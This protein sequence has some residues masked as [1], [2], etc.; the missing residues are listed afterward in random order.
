MDISEVSV[1]TFNGEAALDGIAGS[2]AFAIYDE[3][4]NP[5]GLYSP[6]QDGDCGAPYV[7]EENFLKYVLTVT[8]VNF[9]VGSP[10]FV[11]SYA[12]GKFSTGNDGC[13]CDDIGSGLR[14]E[15]GCKCPFPVEGLP[16]KKRS[17]GVSFKA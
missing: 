13:G 16:D 5:K 11:F 6:D 9:G 1:P 3:D 7:I 14:V 8:S 12:N 15:I 10:K 2:T 17:V 4:C